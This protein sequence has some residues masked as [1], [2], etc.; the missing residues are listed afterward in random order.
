MSGFSSRPLS[1]AGIP[2][3]TY[4]NKHQNRWHSSTDSRPKNGDYSA[5]RHGDVEVTGKWFRFVIFD[6]FGYFVIQSNT[7]CWVFLI[8]KSKP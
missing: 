4:H 8:L 3:P 1:A 5:Y 6:V 7:F 2:N